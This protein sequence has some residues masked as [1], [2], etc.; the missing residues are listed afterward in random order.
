MT[1]SDLDL[2]NQYAQNG[3]EQSFSTLVGRHLALVYSAALRHV[4]SPQLAEDVAQS[5]FA[6]LAR[7]ASKLNQDTILSAWLYRVTSRTAIDLVR[8]E[9][10]RQAREQIA[11]DIAKA[12][13]EPSNWTQIE[14]LLN[15]ALD[16]L[17]E[18]D[19]SAILLRFF[20][21]KSL[22]EV[23]QNL[24]A[25]E[26]AAQKRVSRALERLRDFFS[27]QGVAVGSASLAA[28][29]SSDALH[30]VPVGLGSAI[31]LAVAS[32]VT[33][34]VAATVG[35]TKAI[36]MSTTQKALLTTLVV[37]A[38]GTG[39]YERLQVSHLQSQIRPLVHQI[40]QL[41][42]ERDQA[43]ASLAAAQQQIEQLRGDSAELPRLRGEVARLRADA[44]ELA[45]LK[46]ADPF[47]PSSTSSA[48]MAKSL[49]SRVESLKRKLQERPDLRI[50]ELQLAKERDWILAAAEIK[51][52]TDADLRKAL[53][54]LRNL[55]KN[56]F[57][58][59]AMRALQAYTEA[60]QGQL[61]MNLSDLKSFF[62]KPVDESILQ[63]Y[64]LTQSG[65]ASALAPAAFVVQEK[66]PVDPQND[67]L[68]HIGLR[69]AGFSSPN[70]QLGR[71]YTL[72]DEEMRAEDDENQ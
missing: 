67:S 31:S 71:S 3:S 38:L 30:S 18:T 64:Q 55:A 50:P 1:T 48:E 27:K 12:E 15:E 2:L 44:V 19:R 47:I 41:R 39:V 46:S 14:P 43:S 72:N 63:R 66:A 16:A 32:S 68:F 36:A 26:D 45:R 61:P 69:G 49:A 53:G 24:G 52:G 6:D 22:K 23:G 65:P 54:Q 5:V 29:L 8:R 42:G 21:R 56:R 40:E 62:R 13:A 58:L 35:I 51:A 57:A 70:G 7:N 25:S 4:R 20:E 11:V 10:R 17:E 59:Q 28:V 37:A 34:Q 33:P 9:S 60:N